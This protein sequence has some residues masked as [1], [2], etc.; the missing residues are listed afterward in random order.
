MLQVSETCNHGDL[1]IKLPQWHSVLSLGSLYFADPQ[2]L[3]SNTPPRSCQYAG[4]EAW[5][6]CPYFPSKFSHVI[7]FLMSPEG[8]IRGAALRPKEITC[9][10]WS[11][12]SIYEE[13][14]GHYLEFMPDTFVFADSCWTVFKCR[15]K[16]TLCLL[17]QNQTIP[18][19]AQQKCFN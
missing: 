18:Y 2:I 12:S 6:W 11:R 9:I 5:V 8:V 19:A 3:F 14:V 16:D 4:N 10:I 1:K 7:A 17:F 15:L 13:N